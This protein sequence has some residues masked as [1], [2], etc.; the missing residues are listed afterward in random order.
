MCGPA[1]L[2]IVL[3]YYGIDKSEAEL[4]KLCGVTKKLGTDDKKMAGVAKN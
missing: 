4:A 1:S 2:K 3:D